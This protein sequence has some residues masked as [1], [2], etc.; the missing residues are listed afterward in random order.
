MAD[1]TLSQIPPAMNHNRLAFDTTKPAWDGSKI[2]SVFDTFEDLPLSEIQ[3]AAKDAVSL[4]NPNT[5]DDVYRKQAIP[6]GLYRSGS[7]T[8]ATRAGPTIK[9]VVKSSSI[10]SAQYDANIAAQLFQGKIGGANPSTNS[11]SS[12]TNASSSSASSSSSSSGESKE[13]KEV[14]LEEID[15]DKLTPAQ[16]LDLVAES[17]KLGADF[18]KHVQVHRKYI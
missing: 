18:F 10:M 16:F 9:T 13:S 2:K 3:K 7:S 15:M 6:P 14:G 12:T 8:S 5:G 17:G 11:T 1:L 4:T